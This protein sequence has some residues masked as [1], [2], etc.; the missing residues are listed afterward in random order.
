MLFLFFFLFPAIC[1]SR[2]IYNET[3]AQVLWK[4]TRMTYCLQPNDTQSW[5]ALPDFA[6]LS[7][8]DVNSYECLSL[9]N[10]GFSGY[11]KNDNII[12]LVFRGTHQK[13]IK[14]WMENLLAFKQSFNKCRNCKVHVGFTMAFESLG[15]EKIVKDL[16]N[17]RK[18]YPSAQIAITGHSLGSAMATIAAAQMCDEISGIDHLYTFGSPRVGDQNFASKFC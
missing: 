14:N 2:N 17:L 8:T 18:K 15:K 12:F 4:L 10:F 13:S 7:I 3:L 16:K 11:L 5:N 6:A 9:H 1:F